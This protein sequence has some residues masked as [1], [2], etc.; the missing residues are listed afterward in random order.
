MLFIDK[1]AQNYNYTVNEVTTVINH[2]FTSVW[3]IFWTLFFVTVLHY[4]CQVIVYYCDFICLETWQC[5]FYIILSDF[6]DCS[7]HFTSSNKFWN[8][9]KIWIW[10]LMNFNNQACLSFWFEAEFEVDSFKFWW[11]L[12]SCCSGSIQI[13]IQIIL[14]Q[15]ISLWRFGT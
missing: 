2:V 12:R 15:L 1:N 13:F 7:K 14:H 5:K 10:S 11:N 9:F 3:A 6:T 8:L 4:L